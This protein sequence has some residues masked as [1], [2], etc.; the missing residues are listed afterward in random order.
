MSV[1]QNE[2]SSA[3]LKKGAYALKE[4]GLLQ[5]NPT[6][7]IRHTKPNPDSYQFMVENGPEILALIGR[8]NLLA[9]R[10]VSEAT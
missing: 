2:S 5:P 8:T 6:D 7:D 3:I 9:D 10:L 4:A 1:A